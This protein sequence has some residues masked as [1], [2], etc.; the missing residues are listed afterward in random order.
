MKVLAFGTAA[1]LGVV[2]AAG[3][4]SS[5]VISQQSQPIQGGT[6]DTSN[7]YAI[8]VCVGDSFGQCQL[9]CSGA[10]IAPNLVMTA[11]HCVDQVPTQIDCTNP[12]YDT[13]G[14]LRGSIGNYFITTYFQMLGQST[15]GW[16]NVSQIIT[17]PGT[18][19]CGNDMALLILADNVSLAE[20]GAYVTPVVQYSMTDHTRYSTTV[21]A[22]GYGNT[23]AV[24]QDPGTRRII[25]N[26]NLVCIPGDPLIDCGVQSQIS[27]NEFV[28]GDSTCDGDS[29]SSAYEQKNFN[30]G[31][32]VSFGPLSRGGTSGSTCVQPVYTRTDAWSS[33]IISTAITAAS[34]GGYTPP[35]WTQPIPPDGG[36]VAPDAGS[37]GGV[38]PPPGTLGAPCQTNS[39]CDT[40]LCD[41][42]DGGQT[43]MC[44][45]YCDP[46][47]NGAD[48]TI[49]GYQCVGSTTLP[50]GGSAGYCFPAPP[51]GDDGG[52]AFDN[53][54]GGCNV[55]RAG[56]HDPSK[57]VPWILLALGLV[58]R[59]R[60]SR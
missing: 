11:R 48:C 52:T 29:G 55:A 38:P 12:T 42:D 30:K 4:S 40:G 19:L 21:T 25:Q 46:S 57:P 15:A 3:C 36:T 56:A 59:R 39:D 8:G 47:Q 14:S 16:H 20:A 54:G 33:F 44:T 23:D 43:Y 53:G 18:T 13:F 49:A 45:Q 24:T 60:R 2:L 35:S 10:L 6:T 28:S 5:P 27:A 17:T 51:T 22:I 1:L 31:I 37:D 41:S 34:A 26:V 9:I 32:P 58:V 7:N 50:D